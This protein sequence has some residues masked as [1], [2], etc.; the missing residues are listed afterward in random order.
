MFVLQLF[1][2]RLPEGVAQRIETPEYGLGSINDET[3]LRR[4]CF[5]NESL[6]LVLA[7]RSGAIYTA[8]IALSLLFCK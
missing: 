1:S 7:K 4:G 5:L 3:E 6:Q 8:A 2:C